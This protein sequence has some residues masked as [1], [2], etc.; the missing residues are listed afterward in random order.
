MRQAQGLTMKL[1]IK[2]KLLVV[3]SAVAWL[4]ALGIGCGNS[5]PLVLPDESESSAYAT[6][7]KEQHQE[8]KLEPT[9]QQNSVQQYGDKIGIVPV[10]RS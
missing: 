5:G 7:T 3:F 10:V 6:I 4:S 2:T 9:R 1:G 8:Q